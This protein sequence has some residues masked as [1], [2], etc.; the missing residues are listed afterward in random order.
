MFKLSNEEAHKSD[1]NT[2][3]QSDAKASEKRIWLIMLNLGI[4]LLMCGLLFY[5]VSNQLFR[6]RTD[7]GKYQCYA[8]VFWQGRNAA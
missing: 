2:E 6:P 4:I 8:L 7:A 5:G 3:K 1:K